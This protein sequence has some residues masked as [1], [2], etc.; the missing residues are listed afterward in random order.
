MYRVQLSSLFV[1]D[2][3]HIPEQFVQLANRLFNISYLRLAFD[4]QGIL[5]IYFVLGCE[6]DFLLLLLLLKLALRR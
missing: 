5:K 3:R 4:D 2:M 6:A 1:H